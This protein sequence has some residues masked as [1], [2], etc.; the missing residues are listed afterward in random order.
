MVGADAACEEVE[1]RGGVRTM[2]LEEASGVTEGVAEEEA[3]GVSGWDLD[4]FL[5]RP[6]ATYGRNLFPLL[7]EEG[8]PTWPSVRRG[9]LDASGFR[10]V[11]DFAEAG[12]SNSSP[13]PVYRTLPL[14]PISTLGGFLKWVLSRYSALI[15]RTASSGRD[16]GVRSLPF[17]TSSIL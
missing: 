4:F 16:D 10:V 1:G 12:G 11:E 6:V 3:S 13:S 8:S 17:S 5:G 9:R 14:A 2:E 7:E 15:S